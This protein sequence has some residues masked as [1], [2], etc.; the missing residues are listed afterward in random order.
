[1]YMD[2]ILESENGY[3]YD[4]VSAETMDE[5]DNIEV[6]SFTESALSPYELVSKSLYEFVQEHV[7]MSQAITRAEVNYIKENGVEPLW[8]ASDSE[9]IFQK[10]INMVKKLIGSITGAFDKLM[11]AV[12]TKVRSI[13]EK[14]GNKLND[15]IRYDGKFI[16]DKKFLIRKYDPEYGVAILEDDPQSILHKTPG[17]NTIEKIMNKEIGVNGPWRDDGANKDMIISKN[18]KG[19]EELT[20]AAKEVIPNLNKTIFSIIKG[21]D[22]IDW[23]KTSSIKS[24]LMKVMSPEPVRVDWKGAHDEIKYF[25]QDIKGESLKRHL[26]E[27]YNKIKKDLGKIIDQTKKQ[28][29]KVGT[30]TKKASVVGLYINILNKYIQSMTMTYNATCSVYNAKWAQ[31]IK[32]N[33]QLHQAMS[34]GMTKDDKKAAKERRDEIRN[35]D[36]SGTKFVAQGKK[37]TS[38]MRQVGESYDYYDDFELSFE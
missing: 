18:E 10:F 20:D 6:P 15:R 13:Y 14:Y 1:M 11:K 38:N 3:G 22:R 25:M 9:N 36:P 27:V 31:S 19:K 33:I 34:S 12:E 35:T 26:K 37:N 2:L 21:T 5:I 30:S 17:F 28:A 4:G 32:I 8:E 29:K 7:G 16:G 23:T 24:A